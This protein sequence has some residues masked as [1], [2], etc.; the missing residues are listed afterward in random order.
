MSS[1]PT[2]PDALLTRDQLSDA[3]KESG[4]PVEPSTLAT[5]ATRGGGPPFQKF[6][7]RALYRWGT[8]G[9]EP[10][11][12]TEWQEAA[13]LDDIASPL[14]AIEVES[15]DHATWISIGMAL[16]NETGG[17]DAGLELF[18][19]FS[20]RSPSEYDRSGLLAQGKSFARK[21]PGKR[22][23]TAGTI[24]YLALQ[25][26]WGLPPTDQPS[27]GETSH[28]ED[29]TDKEPPE[30]GQQSADESHT[31]EAKNPDPT[32]QS[33]AETPET[34]DCL[35]DGMLTPQTALSFFNR[36]YMVVKEAG[37]AVI[38]EPLDD[39]MLKRRYFDRLRIADFKALYANRDVLVHKGK[40]KPSS[41]QR[42]SGCDTPSGGNISATWCSGRDRPSPPTPSICGT[43]S[44]SRRS[45]APR[46][47]HFF[48]DYD[49]A[50]S[51]FHLLAGQAWSLMTQNTAGIVARK[52]NIPLTIDASYVVGFEYTRNWQTCLV[53]G[54][55]WT[56]AVSV[57]APAAQIFA[58]G[59]PNNGIVNGVIANWTNPGG[60]FIG[61][62][63][64]FTT[65]TIPDIIEKL[66]YDPGWAHFEL[67]GVQRFFSDN[68][69][70]WSIVTAAGVC[71]TPFSTANTGT[72]NNHTSTGWGIG[73]SFLWSI[74]PNY[75]DLNG[76]MI[77]GQGIGRYSA[78][79]LPDVIVAGD[80]TLHPIKEIA[81][82][83]GP[84]WTSTP[85]AASRRKTPAGTRDSCLLLARR[86]SSPI[87]ALAM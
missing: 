4:F 83:D 68:I 55:M 72:T 82:M 74:L 61:S 45:W 30:D 29:A 13:E 60:S 63:N 23:R 9:G 27:A 24:F 31:P 73:G 48:V 8:T 28:D 22:L 17:S 58:G 40:G 39:P 57:E 20:R 6:G 16:H 38:C 46:L 80:G 1:I 14:D 19:R 51:G 49:S 50:Y 10:Q 76:M 21:P 66:A 78:A 34:A 71:V 59:V 65:D 43:V 47:R 84:A 54:P 53:H 75:L 64:S 7:I 33:D 70:T 85:M 87:W 77:G 35:P 26:G 81:G 32:T 86:Q 69:F 12:Q 15:I 11:G 62:L 67:F 37:K 2:N 52:E 5:K 44:P 18:D 42:G 25:N 41:S 79:Q 3:F 56:A 36:K